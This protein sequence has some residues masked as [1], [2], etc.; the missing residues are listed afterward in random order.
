MEIDSIVLDTINI[1][2]NYVYNYHEYED[3]NDHEIFRLLR[4]KA[5]YN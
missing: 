2:N 1:K 5:Y 3:E 4:N